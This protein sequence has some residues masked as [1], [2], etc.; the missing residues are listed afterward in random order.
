MLWLH[1]EGDNLVHHE[2]N[3]LMINPLIWLSDL[4]YNIHL[5]LS[6][7][8]LGGVTMFSVHFWHLHLCLYI[9][10]CCSNF[11]FSH[12]NCFRLTLIIWD[13]ESKGLG[14][15]TGWPFCDLD[16]KSQLWHWLTDICLSAWWS[17]TTHPTT[18]EL[19]GNIPLIMLIIWLNFGGI[20]IETF[21]W[22]YFKNHGQDFCRQTL[23]WP[24]LRNG[25]SDQCE[26]HRKGISWILCQL[27]HLYLWCHSWPWPWFLR[28]VF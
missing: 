24:Y 18:T 25:W 17:D 3:R 4:K 21:F 8:G 26:M 23:N 11:C 14:K 20:L 22:H 6:H 19:D 1:L 13:S 7:P 5:Y 2:F 10:R 9:C 12:Q 16:P 15:G 27:W 28:S